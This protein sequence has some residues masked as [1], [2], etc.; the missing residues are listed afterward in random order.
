MK[1]KVTITNYNNANNNNN[2]INSNTKW[3]EKKKKE[4]KKEERYFKGKKSVKLSW[5]WLPELFEEVLYN[6][7]ISSFTTDNILKMKAQW[8]FNKKII[9]PIET[10]VPSVFNS[11]T[12]HP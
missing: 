6:F 8:H 4:K 11:F 5:L 10:I 7:M 12:R 1:Q 2:Y 9:K 3:E